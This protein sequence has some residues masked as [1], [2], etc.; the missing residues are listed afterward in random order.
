MSRRGQVVG[1]LLAGALLAVAPAA[2]QALDLGRAVALAL[3]RNPALLAVEELRGQV[4]GG[5]REARADAFPQIALVSAWGQS[6]S[7]AFLN[8]PDFGEF[9]DQLPP[10][11]FEPS[12]QEL[13]RTV[14]EVSQ[15]IWNFGKVGAAV[16]LAKIVADAA[17]AQIATARLDTALAAAEAYYGVLSSREGLATI[18]AEREYR[19]DDLARVENLLE[20]GEATELEHLRARAAFAEV[21]P[22]VARRQGQVEVAETRFRQVLALPAG[23]PVELEA[24][25]RELPAAPVDDALIAAALERRPE[26]RDLERQESVYVK[27]QKITRADGLPAIDLNGTWG[28]EVRLLDN[29]GDPL[30]DAWSVSIG[31]RW[32]MFDGG[33]RKGQ[34]AQFES[35]R[36]QLALQRADLESRIRLESREALTA[37]RTALARA[38]AAEFAAATAREAVRVARESYEQG[39]A[40]QTDLLDAQS[41]NVAAEVVA[42]EAFYDARI[43]AARLARAAGLDPT[44]SWNFPPES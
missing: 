24:A 42:V 9:L 43:E 3:E 44:Q 37:Y 27:R 32:E 35:Q 38:A 21:E 23:Q 8:S 12:T 25:G 4:A 39:V 1:G 2:P 41:R 17:D 28:R 30:Y 6:R 19:R 14:L 22:E 36:Q 5:I 10:G 31:M 18:E 11:S 7:P 15:P 34:I 13:Y 33:R 29:F 16:E 26:L 20:I 40:T